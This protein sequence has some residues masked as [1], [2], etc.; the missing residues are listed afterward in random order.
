[1]EKEKYI[2]PF[3]ITNEIVNLVSN[4]SH[5]LGKVSSFQGVSKLPHLRKTNRIRSVHSSLVIEGNTLS[6]DETKAILNGKTVSAPKEDILAVQNAYEAYREAPKVDLF[7][8][9][10]ILDIHKIMMN[11]LIDSAGSFRKGDVGVFDGDTPVHI[12]PPQQNISWLIGDLLEWT[13]TADVNPL[14]KY[15]VFHYEFEYIH[16]FSDGNGRMG[17]LWHTR[18]LSLYDEFFSFLPIESIIEERQEEYYNAF[19][20]SNSDS[21]STHFIV[22]ILK[23]IL[24]AIC[25]TT[26]DVE[27]ELRNVNYSVYSLLD[28]M[29]NSTLSAKELMAKM[30]L[31]SLLSFKK[32]YLIPAIEQNLISLTE[33]NKPT[34]RNQRYF[35]TKS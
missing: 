8:I 27:N 15:A 13:K 5:E 7:N 21:K 26:L 22:F 33:P 17:R 18:L 9:K 6:I 11:G 4:I 2:P 25:N 20:L 10:S 12:A 35:K 28:V 14:I 31:K 23:V 16:P 32:N 1:M 34:S 30:G 3:E 24:D 19:R 29:G